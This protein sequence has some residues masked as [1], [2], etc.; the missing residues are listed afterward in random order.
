MTRLNNS[1]GITLPL[2]VWL[3][4]D[5]YDYVADPNYLSVTSIMK[6][7]R[8]IVLA[9]RVK[10][11]QATG[12]IADRI[13]STMGTALHDSIEKAWTH[14]HRAAMESLGYSKDIA[15]RIVINPEPSYVKKNPECIPIY[16]EQRRVKE[17][18][19]FRIGGKYDF[20]GEG[21]VNDFKST[22]TYTYQYGT[23]DKDYTLQGSLYKWLNPDIITKDEIAI[24][25]IFTDWQKFRAKTEADKGYPQLKVLEHRV[26]LMTVKDT[27]KWLKNKIKDIK[28]YMD[29]PDAEI[30]LCTNEEL[31]RG[32]TQ[33]KYYKNPANRTR[34]TKNF[35][36]PISANERLAKDGN[37][38]V[39]VEIGGQVKAC[40]YCSA[41][42]VC[43]QAKSLIADGS[44]II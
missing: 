38:G 8:Q 24:Q 20:V 28:T 12:D 21:R 30:P 10:E 29:A 39:V 4:H 7:V 17:I 9:R 16:M 35:T 25:F 40:M 42:L 34:A 33:W 22:S 3:A 19:G 43:E 26:P 11:D 36:D 6:P 18:M 37:V 15:D 31:W 44:L 14:H 32:E 27:E 41:M 13:A 1:S 23:K 2:A 5:T